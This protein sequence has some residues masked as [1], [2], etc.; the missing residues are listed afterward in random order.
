MGIER[1]VTLTPALSRGEREK[2][3]E[4]KLQPMAFARSLRKQ[5]TEAEHIMW[6]LLRDKQLEG[7]KFRRQHPIGKYV[8][9]FYCHEARL[10]VELDGGQHNEPDEI[11]KDEVRSRFLRSKGITVVR[12]WN[13]EVLRETEGV[14]EGVLSALTP[15]LSQREREKSE[16]EES[17]RSPSPS[18]R[19]IKGE[20]K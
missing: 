5:S 12:F 7:F 2:S 10:G 3:E 15:A 4:G 13:N 18:G 19:G 16:K 1:N 20:G 17:S 8:L 11:E 9:D 6:R 14:L